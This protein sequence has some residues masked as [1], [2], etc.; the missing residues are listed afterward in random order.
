MLNILIMVLSALS[1]TLAIWSLSL[2]AK[3]RKE[4]RRFEEEDKKRIKFYY[5][6]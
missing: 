6:R 4:I 5:G 1:L 2:N 3:N